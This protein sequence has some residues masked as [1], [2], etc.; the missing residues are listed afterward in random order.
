MRRLHRDATVRRGDQTVPFMVVFD[1]DPGP[2]EV[3]G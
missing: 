3:I 1:Y 2:F